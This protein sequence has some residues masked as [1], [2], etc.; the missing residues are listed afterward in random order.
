MIFLNDLLEATGGVLHNG[1]VATEFS[2]FAFNSRQ[3]KSG[4]LFLAVKTTT[5]DGHDYIGTALDKGATG[6]LCE[7]TAEIP[8]N[9]PPATVVIVPDVKQAL[10]EYAAFIL[11]KYN[12]TVIGITGSA[13]KTTAKDA[14]AAVLQKKFQVFKNSGSRNTTYGL[15]IALGDLEP[16]HEI[17]VLE[18]ASDTFGEIA[19]LAR[20]T[21]PKVGVI[22]N[23]NQAHISV[24]GSLNN[25][26]AEKARLIEALPFNGSAILNADNPRVAGMVPRTQAR[27]ITFGLKT[28]ADVRADNLSV[29]PKGLSFTLHYEGKS[30]DGFTPLLGRHQ[31]YHILAAVA[32]GLVF[33]ISPELS[34]SALS[35]LP[36]GKGRMNLLRGKKAP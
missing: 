22:T 11:Q 2:S 24:L 15:P 34:L 23:I 3:I 13:G 27:I 21:Q 6:V 9:A 31:I 18:M 25:I 5:G 4:Q 35:K 7:T 26:A 1:T 16:Q 29:S 10:T 33:K 20:I 14:I 19:T 36:R 30:Y 12:P 28:G 17:A 8:D 32:T